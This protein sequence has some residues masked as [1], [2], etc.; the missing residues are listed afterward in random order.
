MKESRQVIFKRTF[1]TRLELLNIHM[2]T[3]MSVDTPQWW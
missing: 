3:Y 1:T 2:Y